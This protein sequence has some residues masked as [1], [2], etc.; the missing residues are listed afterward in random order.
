[1][2][3]V[4]SN[5]YLSFKCSLFV[6]IKYWRKCWIAPEHKVRNINVLIAKEINGR[7]LQ[8]K[9]S[10]ESGQKTFTVATEVNLALCGPLAYYKYL[11]RL[12][13]HFFPRLF[14]YCFVTSLFL[15]KPFCRNIE[16]LFHFY[17]LILL[18]TPTVYSPLPFPFF[19]LLLFFCV[20]TWDIALSTRT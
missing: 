19:L 1:M 11:W 3:I 4:V 12:S 2:I 15:T 17:V 16:S 14:I 9:H 10:L 8:L 7:K 20:W 18:F 6:V 13:S 5:C